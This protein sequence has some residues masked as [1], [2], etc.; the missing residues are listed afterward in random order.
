MEKCVSLKGNGN[1]AIGYVLGLMCVLFAQV[2]IAAEPIQLKNPFNL[3]EV[4]WVKETGDSSVK[5][6]AFLKLS[7]G[8]YKGCAGF[9]VELLPVAKYSNERI[10]NTYGNNE[11]G[12]ILLKQNP[13]KFT[14]DVKEYHDMVIKAQCNE[15]NEFS[16]SQIKA[17]DYYVIGFIMWDI[18]ANPQALKDGGAVMKRIHINEKEHVDVLLKN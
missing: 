2:T 17:G 3:D 4:K 16:F 5:G 6:K 15:N 14:P 12:Q 8:E 9:N 1:K 10:Y 11:Q 7:N 18:N 13:P